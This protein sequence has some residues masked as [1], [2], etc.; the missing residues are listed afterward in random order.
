MTTQNISDDSAGAS[1]F[2][3]YA[4]LYDL[5]AREVEGLSDEQLDFDS[6]KWGWSEWSIRYQ[7]S[8]MASLLY[9]WMLVRW[10]DVLF[11][12]GNH[13][14]DDVKG[15]TDS[16]FDRRMDANVYKE[17]PA[18][19]EKLKGG[20]DLV[21]GILAER[22]VGFLRNHTIPH[23]RSPQWA[24]MFK[25][26]PSGITPAEESTEGTMALEATMRHMYFEE[27]THLYNIQ[28]LKRA[29]GLQAVVDLPRVGYWVL[30]G[31]DRSEP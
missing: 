7:L 3:E 25:A 12:D 19:L 14:V 28:R 10:G 13:G 15:L 16:G 27:I 5:I 20:I 31:W 9:R 30:D 21:Q 4:S 6:D 26:H 17:L 1:L 8:H 18:I 22:N 23:Q 29:Q 2:P 24:V 11:P